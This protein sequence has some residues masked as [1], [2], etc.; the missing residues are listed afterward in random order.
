MDKSETNVDWKEE[1]R[2]LAGSLVGIG[3]AWARYGLTVGRMALETTAAS[4]QATA[5]SLGGLADRIDDE[6]EAG[7]IPDPLPERAGK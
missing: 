1:G 6:L 2:E 3:G 4:L 7:D 5:S